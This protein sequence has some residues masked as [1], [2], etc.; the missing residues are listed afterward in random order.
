MLGML[1]FATLLTG[2]NDSA[3]KA[4]EAV[5]Y[6]LR[7]PESDEFRN[8]RI[9]NGGELVCG[10]VNATNA[11]GGKTGFKGFAY[12]DDQ[13]SLEDSEYGM[14][15]FIA[16]LE[17]CTAAVQKETEVIMKSLPPEA[18]ARVKAEASK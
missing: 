5:K 15:A 6:E 13:A 3:S 18:Q 11:Y 4:K 2:C 17:K 12:V 9:Y 14:T 10:E 1:I 7:D 16:G 8:L